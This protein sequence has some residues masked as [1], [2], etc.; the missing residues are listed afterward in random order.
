MNGDPSEPQRI[1]PGTRKGPDTERLL[2]V[3]SYGILDSPAEDEFDDL[4]LLAARICEAPIAAISFI[5]T[6]RQWFKARLGLETSEM[7]CR[8][9]FCHYTLQQRDVYQVL[10][11]LAGSRFVDNPLVHGRIGARFYAGAPL[12]TR[13]G[14]A[15]GTLFVLDHRV[16]DL[17]S[18]QRRCLLALSRQVIALLEAR[19]AARL[20]SRH[21]VELHQFRAAAER[22]IEVRA[23]D[24]KAANDQLESFAYSVSHDLCSPLRAIDNYSQMLM[25]DFGSAMGREANRQLE[26]ITQ[27]VRQ[28]RQLITGLL[29]FSRFSRQ[30]LHR[31]R[32]QLKK[33][34]TGILQEMSEERDDRMQF[35]E[36]GD[37]PDCHAD[38][39]LLKQIFVNLLRNAFK[40]TR[41][42]NPPRIS[43]G[44]ESREG[45]V[46]YFVR[47]NGVGFDMHYADRLF[48][49]FQRLHRSDEF[50]GTGV[51]LSIV[52]RIIHRHGGRV[53]AEGRVSQGATFFFTLAS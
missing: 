14:C 5:E 51:G 38:P 17:T 53:W 10:D 23:A 50:E 16:R 20:Q 30:P 3:A 13:T 31:Q 25:R 41:S 22:H 49:V 4:A 9:G 34:V 1:D 43:I 46:I 44:S 52:K 33:F 35:V 45:E 2:E 36:I 28:M 18:E 29:Q 6:D 12:V 21:Q 27:N 42:S 48:G 15:I 37:L 26:L 39:L 24:L 19:R 32:I 40:F 7:S 11:A 8:Q 47:D